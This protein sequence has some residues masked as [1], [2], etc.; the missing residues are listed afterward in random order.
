MSLACWLLLAARPAGE[1]ESSQGAL[2]GR[3][4]RHEPTLPPKKRPSCPARPSRGAAGGARG[5]PFTSHTHTGRS[6]LPRAPRKCFVVRSGHGVACPSVSTSPLSVTTSCLSS[7]RLANPAR[8]SV[9]RVKI[10]TKLL[11]CCQLAATA[12]GVGCTVS[13]LVNQAYCEGPCKDLSS[14]IRILDTSTCTVHRRP[15]SFSLGDPS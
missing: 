7:R 8:A 2:A 13:F 15:R 14:H 3:P 12:I 10:R 1:H 6:W 11:L 9:C 5:A 4:C